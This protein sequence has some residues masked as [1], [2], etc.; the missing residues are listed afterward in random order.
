MIKETLCET[1]YS[2]QL[3]IVLNEHSNKTEYIILPVNDC[4]FESDW[5]VGTQNLHCKVHCEQD[6][7]FQSF[8][9]I[10]VF[11]DNSSDK[12]KENQS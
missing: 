12:E 2:T 10:K 1:F 4:L 7:T 5:T 6:S 8:K 9:V 3:Q 11:R